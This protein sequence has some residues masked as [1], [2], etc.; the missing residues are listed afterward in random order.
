[1][2][3]PHPPELRQRAV[4]AYRNNEGTYDE[5]AKRFAI[6]VASLSRYLR[7]QRETGGVEPRQP[8]VSRS[9]KQIQGKVLDYLLHLVKDEPN[10]STSEL[11][12]ELGE[13]FDLQLDRRTVGEALRDAGYTYKRGSSAQQL[14]KGRMLWRIASTSERNSGRSIPPSS[15]S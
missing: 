13:T 5:I 2:P 1:M 4:D 6:G 8:E 14:P 9:D 7:L 12:A 3:K 10:W 15:S 11:A